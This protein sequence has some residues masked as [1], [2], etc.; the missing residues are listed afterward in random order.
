MANETYGT[1]AP[2]ILELSDVKVAAGGSGGS[3]SAVMSEIQLNTDDYI[4]TVDE[5]PQAGVTYYTKSGDVYTQ[6]TG[7]SFASGTTY[8]VSNTVA[9]GTRKA[10]IVEDGVVDEETHNGNADSFNYSVYLKK[11][12]TGSGDPV[13]IHN[14]LVQIADSSDYNPIYVS[15]S[16]L[17]FTDSNNSRVCMR[18]PTSW[19]DILENDDSSEWEIWIRRVQVSAA[20]V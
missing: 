6:F 20:E 15:A 8:Y 12:I 11:I 1:K 17:I 19:L 9:I 7:S 13:I 2:S 4:E 5:T 10:W 3:G 18:K 14:P 16:S